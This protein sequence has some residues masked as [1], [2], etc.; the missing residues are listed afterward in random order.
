VRRLNESVKFL[1][2]IKMGLLDY[3]ARTK[4]I[5]NYKLLLSS[6]LVILIIIVKGD[7]LRLLLIHFLFLARPTRLGW[8]QESKKKSTYYSVDS[9]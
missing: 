2:L 4:S 3:R 5:M 8:L 7:P 6:I 9:R 1:F